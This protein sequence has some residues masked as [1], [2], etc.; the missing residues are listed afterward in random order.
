MVAPG[1]LDHQVLCTL[2][3]LAHQS[4]RRAREAREAGHHRLWRQHGVVGDVA[5]V[6]QDAAPALCAGQSIGERRAATTDMPVAFFINIS[7]EI[8]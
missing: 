5:A 7:V 3:Q 2:G 4:A 1:E 8:S 6:L